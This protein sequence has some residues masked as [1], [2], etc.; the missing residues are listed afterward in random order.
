[1]HESSHTGIV[2]I[3]IVE[4]CVSIQKEQLRVPVVRLMSPTTVSRVEV[5][6]KSLIYTARVAY[7]V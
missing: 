1:M 4:L 2:V 5:P 3:F 6:F 7:E